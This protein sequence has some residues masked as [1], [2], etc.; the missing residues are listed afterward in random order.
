MAEPLPRVAQSVRIFCKKCDL[1]RP[2]RVLA[3]MTST[4]AKTECEICHSKQT[5]RAP[6]SV[7]A[8]TRRLVRD[9]ST[10]SRA[11]R[12]SLRE[13]WVQLKNDVGSDR[14]EAYVPHGSFS[15]DAT[16]SHPTFG[17]G[18]VTL[19]TPSKIEVIFEDGKR[20]LIHNVKG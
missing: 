7:T 3:H 17:L 2:H 20:T 9:P 4:T 13:T 8:P 12:T 14:P 15:K 11:P 10:A 1:E 19:S 5:Y 6:G 18:F 16:I